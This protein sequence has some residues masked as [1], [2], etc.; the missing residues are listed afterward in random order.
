ML[1]RIKF[2][3][4]LT[5]LTLTPFQAQA[6]GYAGRP[7]YW[8]DDWSWGHMLSGS[9]MMFLF[10][11]GIILV[12]VLLVRSIGSGSAGGIAAP[13]VGKSPLDILNERFAC[14]EIDKEEFEDRKKRLSD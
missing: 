3:L 4:I 12:V 6:Q 11:G 2:T 14:G 13:S 8:H 5:A 1:D 10:W 9:L 7:G